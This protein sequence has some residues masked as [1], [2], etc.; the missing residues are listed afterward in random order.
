MQWEGVEWECVE[1]GGCGVGGMILQGLC[2]YGHDCKK[3]KGG[4]FSRE[5]KCGGIE[6]FPISSR[7]CIGWWMLVQLW[8][9]CACGGC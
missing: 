6:V 3:E 7:G 4:M 1:Q 9:L 8:T 2:C 5:R